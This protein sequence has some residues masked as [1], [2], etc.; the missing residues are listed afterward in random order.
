MD[1]LVLTALNDNTARL[2][3]TDGTEVKVL[4]GHEN[5]ITAAAFSP[6]G[7]LVATG[8]LDGTAR[9]WSIED[10]SVARHVEGPQRAADG[11]R[12]QPGWS[13]DRDRFTRSDGPHL[14]RQGW[15]RAACAQRARRRRDQCCIQS[16]R[17][18]RG[19]G[20]VTGSHGQALGRGVLAGRLRS[21]PAKR[22]RPT[23]QPAFTRA[24]FN[25][26]G[27]RITIVS[28]DES[29]RIV[30]VFPT[31]QD[32]IDYARNVVAARTDALRAQALLPPRRRRCRGVP[33][34]R[35]GERRW[36]FRFC[37]GFRMPAHHE[38]RHRHGAGVRKPPGKEPAGRLALRG[39]SGSMA[40]WA[41][42]GGVRGGAEAMERG[43]RR[44]W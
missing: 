39:V 4:A 12:V 37:E 35:R 9:V 19:D 31:P 18:L 7:R 25:P 41:C 17:P 15:C 32:L 43:D 6:D 24:E 38:R 40:I 29:A 26:D 20:V 3:K 30:R 8:S 10:G 16:Q 21:L 34:L 27:T 14:A 44:C 28:G 23:S 22:T 42:R 33:R 13:V 36:N 11:C 1:N 5:R 2:W